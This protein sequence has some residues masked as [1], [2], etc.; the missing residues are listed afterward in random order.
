MPKERFWQK[1]IEKIDRIDKDKVREYILALLKEKGLLENIFN[2]LAE[3]IIVLDQENNPVYVNKYLQQILN[4]DEDNLFESL[5]SCDRKLAYLVLEEKKEFAGEEIQIFEPNFRVLHISRLKFLFPH[6]ESSG[7]IVIIDDITERKRE[8]EEKSRGERFAVLSQLASGVAHEIG[9][10]LNSLQIHLQLLSK[11]LKSLSKG[12]RGKLTNYIEVIKEEIERLDSIVS[13]FLKASRPAPLNWEEKRIEKILEEVLKIL[14]PE[15][16]KNKIEVKKNYASH[17]PPILL[18]TNQMKQAFLNVLKNSIEA[19]PKGG[20][21]SISTFI[22]TD[23][24]NIRFTDSGKGIPEEFLYRIFEP[25][26]TTKEE[27][28]GLG[29]M[30]TLRIIKAHGGDIKVRSE[31]DKGTEITIVIPLK[32]GK[33]PLPALGRKKK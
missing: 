20:L 9:N 27:G 17:I 4:I 5:A 24:L 25:Y 15:L 28:S 16:R 3:G 32:R 2:S 14:S 6:Q 31:E 10:P 8:E 19:M 1:L 29:L 12:Q 30:I 11:G 18:D 7:A 21:V 23:R 26:F 22:T 33:V 13:E